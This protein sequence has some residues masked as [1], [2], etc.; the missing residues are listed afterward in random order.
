MTN[1]NVPKRQN[2]L[3]KPSDKFIN[4][5]AHFFVFGTLIFLYARQAQIYRFDAFYF[6]KQPRP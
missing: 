1:P 2:V 5:D 3:L 4:A 6:K